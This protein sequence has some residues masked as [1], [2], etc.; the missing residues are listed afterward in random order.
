MKWRVLVLEEKTGK[1]KIYIHDSSY[2]N[3]SHR[4]TRRKIHNVEQKRF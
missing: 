2:F 1:M 4:R 3:T